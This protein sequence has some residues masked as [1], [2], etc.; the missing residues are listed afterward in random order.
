[1]SEEEM[2]D[3]VDLEGLYWQKEF[4]SWLT[5][6]VSDWY[7]TA[8]LENGEC[9]VSYLLTTDYGGFQFFG[10]IERPLNGMTVQCNGSER[11]PTSMQRAE[12]WS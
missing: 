7:C 3:L 11:N 10:C 2:K 6:D 4:E 12:R 5:Y 9:E 8:D 1:M